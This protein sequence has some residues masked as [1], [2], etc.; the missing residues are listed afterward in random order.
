[1]KGLDEKFS[2]IITNVFFLSNSHLRK[3]Y[4]GQILR[5]IKLMTW[6]SFYSYIVLYNILEISR[7]APLLGFYKKLQRFWYLIPISWFSLVIVENRHRGMIRHPTH[8]QHLHIE[9]YFQIFILM[10]WWWCNSPLDY[11]SCFASPSSTT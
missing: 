9:A 6:N 11:T 1:M 2:N 8:A 10:C 4:Y 3:K 7:V 5:D